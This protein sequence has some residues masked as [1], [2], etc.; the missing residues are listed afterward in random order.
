VDVT[1]RG[2]TVDS[3]HYVDFVHQTG[4]HWRHLHSDPTCLK[5]LL[6]HHDNARPHTAAN[7]KAFF[8]KR[9]VELI[10]Q[11]PYS[12]DLNQCD[13]WLFKYLKTGLKRR[14]LTSAEDVRNGTLELFHQIPPQR[15]AHELEN[16]KKHCQDVIA[17]HGDYVTNH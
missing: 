15:F 3:A 13:R 6:W 1:D 4:E 8:N 7:T 10:N 11:A 2:E 12:P 17:R 9:R 14:T 5:E 16:L